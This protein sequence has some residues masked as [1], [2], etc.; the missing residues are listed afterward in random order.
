MLDAALPQYLGERVLPSRFPSSSFR[1]RA[2]ELAQ[3]RATQVVRSIRRRQAEY[4]VD[5][6]HGPIIA[7]TLG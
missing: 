6:S 7:A 5:Q 3:I 1:R 4:P 2:I